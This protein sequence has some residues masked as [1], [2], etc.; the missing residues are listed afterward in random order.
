MTADTIELPPVEVEAPALP[1]E[2]EEPPITQ[3]R[4]PGGLPPIWPWPP[5]VAEVI[6]SGQI[7]NTWESVE[8][9]I[10]YA[11]AW[12]SFKF[13][14]VEGQNQDVQGGGRAP[15]YLPGQYV[16]IKL[17]GQLAVT[18]IIVTRQTAYDATHHQIQFEGRGVTWLA[19]RASHLD[20]TGNFDGMSFLEA[21]ETVLAPFAGDGVG[22]T[23]RGELDPK[24]FPKLQIQPGETIWNFI[25][26]IGRP[27]GVV[28]GTDPK[29]NFIFTGYHTTEPGDMVIEGKNIKTCNAIL[30]IEGIF[31]EYDVRGSQP[32]DDQTNGAAASE[33]HGEHPGDLGKYSARSYSPNL[34]PAEE[35]GDQS[36]MQDRA[37]HEHEWHDFT[38]AQAVVTVYGWLQQNGL[39]WQA[40]QSV[41]LY[42]PMIPF[43]QV[44]SVQRVTFTQ[45][46]AHGTLTTLDL[47]LPGLLQGSAL[48]N[49]SKGVP[50]ISDKPKE[51]TTP[52]KQPL[53]QQQHG[54]PRAQ[55]APPLA[56]P[57]NP[58][59]DWRIF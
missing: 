13:Q 23:I 15:M 8:V 7:S 12:P 52:Q 50:D 2:E 36:D 42:S 18:G 21:A 28:I 45:S 34:T 29:G 38:Y 53:P 57:A 26:R 32:G 47:V 51:G 19:A 55:Q 14:T 49:V 39:L 56:P 11:E 37:K 20:T 30:S 27:R 16:Q 41:L 10:N 59:A 40:G 44:M 3:L 17:G 5:E 54:A 4:P 43:N 24:P 25:E 48:F 46:S 58:F 22:I 35:P 31:S 6:V 9:Q 1:P 33:V